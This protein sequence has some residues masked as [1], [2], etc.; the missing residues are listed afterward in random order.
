[1]DADAVDRCS[2]LH[3][4]SCFSS[5]KELAQVADEVDV[6]MED[7]KSKDISKKEEVKN[8]MLED[9][10]EQKFEQVKNDAE[11]SDEHKV[12]NDDDDVEVVE[13]DDESV[14][15]PQ[16]ESASVVKYSVKTTPYLQ[17]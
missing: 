4:D 6:E 10:D 9:F 12:K 13:S 17:R 5:L 8:K 14:K 3:K 2:C 16:M 7:N 11:E 15:T 1:M